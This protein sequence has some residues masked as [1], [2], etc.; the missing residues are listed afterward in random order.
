MTRDR[1]VR[2]AR[3]AATT[4]TRSREPRR[5]RP[6]HAPAVG[7]AERRAGSP[8]SLTPAAPGPLLAVLLTGDGGWAAGDKFDGT[9]IGPARRRGRGPQLR[10]VCGARAHAGRSGRRPRA[11]SPS[12]PRRVASAAHGP[13]RLFPG[14]R[15]HPVHGVAAAGRPAHIGS[16][17][18]RCSGRAS[19][20]ASSSACWTSRGRTHGRTRFGYSRRWPSSAAL[21]F[22]ACMGQGIGARFVR[23]WPAL[24]SRGQ[25]NTPAVIGCPG[26]TGRRWWTRSSTRCRNQTDIHRAAPPLL[27]EIQGERS[28]LGDLILGETIPGRQGVPVRRSAGKTR[29]PPSPL[30]RVQ[31]DTLGPR[32]PCPPGHIRCIPPPGVLKQPFTANALAAD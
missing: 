2:W 5:R 24:V 6:H 25:S 15:P 17:S 13:H 7:G 10:P 22:S 18:R 1:R 20:R 8:L 29:V 26:E 31:S 11:H 32:A 9:G 14:R 19:G 30:I 12:F 16:R 28:V 27:D 21:R 23:R 4:F 3:H